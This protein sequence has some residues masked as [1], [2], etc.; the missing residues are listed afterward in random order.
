MASVV[1]KRTGESSNKRLT[2][3]N[4][5]CYVVRC[6]HGIRTA[7]EIRATYMVEGAAD[8][9][10]RAEKFME[11]TGQEFETCHECQ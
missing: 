1:H 2:K 6:I 11:L 10:A 7:D 9:L 4:S 8:G 3:W 5:Q